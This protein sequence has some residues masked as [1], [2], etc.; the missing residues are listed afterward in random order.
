MRAFASLLVLALSAIAAPSPRSGHVVHEKR[1]RD[2]TGWE[3]SRRV[4][5][6][7]VCQGTPEL[8]KFPLSVPRA[9][10]SL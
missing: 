8:N 9:P 2:P 4:E 3:Q 7:T 6:D 1:A 5:P 10:P